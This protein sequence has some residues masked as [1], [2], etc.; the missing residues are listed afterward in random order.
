MPSRSGFSAFA[1]TALVAIQATI[2]TSALE[3]HSQNLGQPYGG[4]HTGVAVYDLN[5]DGFLDLLFA[6]GRHSL[7]TAFVLINLG[8][9]DTKDDGKPEFVFSDPLP[10]Q[11]G[12]FYQ[13]DVATLSS[14]DPGHLAV[15]LA[16]GTGV[17]NTPAV[18]LDV[19]VS[20]CS[21]QY[22]LRECQLNASVIWTEPDP[23]GNR[24]GQFSFELGNDVDPALVLVGAGCL[25]IYHPTK[26]G[27][28]PDTPDF[29]MTPEEKVTDFEDGIRRSS[30][31]TVGTI[32][33]QAALVLATRTTSSEAADAATPMVV[34]Y[35]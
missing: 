11:Y 27:N 29:S 21:V 7:D 33:D 2:S 1:A 12:G 32:G 20:G 18:I 26:D 10:L 8:R 15:L 35:Q 25:A 22:P 16:G 24:D 4:Q 9:N 5:G 6:A 14:L 17:F 34:V 13:V 3:W 28:F 23:A 19:L 30:A 31:V